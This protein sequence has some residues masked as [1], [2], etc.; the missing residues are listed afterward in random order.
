[1]LCKL[2]DDTA[3][4]LSITADPL[5][6]ASVWHDVASWDIIQLCCIYLFCHVNVAEYFILSAKPYPTL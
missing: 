6:S 1:M 2:H 4:N 5:F 3:K